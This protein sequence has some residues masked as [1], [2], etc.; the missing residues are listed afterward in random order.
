MRKFNWDDL[1][2]A[3][4]KEFDRLETQRD[5]LLRVLKRIL[6][7]WESVPEDAQVP[8]EINDNDH[9]DAVRAVIAQT[10]GKA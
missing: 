5:E 9:W 10:E 4:K 7:D 8:D 3:Q 6:A 2:Y 1:D